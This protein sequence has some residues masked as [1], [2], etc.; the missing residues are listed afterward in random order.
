[1]ATATAAGVQTSITRYPLAD[2][3]A[4]LAD[5]KEGAFDGAAVLIP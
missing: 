5:L 1:M 2:A 4:A 3:N